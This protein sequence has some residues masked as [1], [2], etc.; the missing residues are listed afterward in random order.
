MAAKSPATPL[1]MMFRR[2]RK[3][4]G[5]WNKLFGVNPPEDMERLALELFIALEELLVA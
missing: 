2:L 4:E 3:S 1:Q 5:L